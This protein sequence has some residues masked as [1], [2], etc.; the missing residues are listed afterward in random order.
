MNKAHSSNSFYITVVVIG[1]VLLALFAGAFLIG[2]DGDI[3]VTTTPDTASPTPIAPTT[4]AVV[5]TATSAPTNTP[6]TA[7]SPTTTLET[8]TPVSGDEITPPTP[9]VTLTLTP[10]PSL[11]PTLAPTPITGIVNVG[12]LNVRLGTST[13]F[14]YAG[15]VYENDEVII[16]G[17]D[18]AGSWYNI[19]TSNERIGWAAARYI[20]IDETA[21][22]SLEV[23]PTPPLPSVVRSGLALPGEVDFLQDHIDVGIR[24][25]SGELGPFAEHWYTFFEGCVIQI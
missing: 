16:L 2:A 9:T 8:P 7:S 13:E 22:N 6:A 4:V 23:I 21:K 10:T 11:T 1:V 17:R 12:A 24:S 5:P 14:G 19:V 25:V 18:S 20:D 3:E 15:G